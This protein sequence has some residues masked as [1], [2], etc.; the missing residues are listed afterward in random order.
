MVATSATLPTTNPILSRRIVQIGERTFEVVPYLG[1]K[2]NN[3]NKHGSRVAR[4]DLVQLVILRLEK[5]VHIKKSVAT[6]EA[7]TI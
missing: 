2:V 4:K 6:E 3:D 7:G 5:S 1:S